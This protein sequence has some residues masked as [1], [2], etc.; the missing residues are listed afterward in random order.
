MCARYPHLVSH[1]FEIERNGKVGD[2]ATTYEIYETGD[3]PNVTIE[4]FEVPDPLGS[5]VLDKSA[6]ELNYYL[7]YGVFPDGDAPSP[8]TRRASAPSN[9]PVG[10]RTPDGNSRREAF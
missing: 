1:E 3:D 6:D 8:V 9:E 4:D 5:H 2:T 7:D 10:R